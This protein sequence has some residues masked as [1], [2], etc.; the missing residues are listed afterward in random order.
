[1]NHAMSRSKKVKD[2]MDHP[3]VVA[4]GLLALLNPT[5]KP[6][7]AAFRKSGSQAQIQVEVSCSRYMMVEAR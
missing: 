2:Q 3:P 1:M 7:V 6:V 4:V 5:L